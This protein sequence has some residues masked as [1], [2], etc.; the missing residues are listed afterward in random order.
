M[1]PAIAIPKSATSKPTVASF[2]GSI[3]KSH[4]QA[5]VF[6]TQVKG[7]D[8]FAIH[9]ALDEFVDASLPIFDTLTESYQGSYEVVVNY[10]SISLVNYTSKEDTIAYF[11]KELSFIDANRLSLFNDSDIINVI[12]NYKTLLRQTLYKL[13]RL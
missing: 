9:L 4:V 10:P 7:A 13:K 8:R 1:P 5:K 2:L 3:L 12:D 6:H 11:E